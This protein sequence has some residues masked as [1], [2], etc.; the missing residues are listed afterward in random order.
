MSTSLIDN[1]NII[2]PLGG[3]E[4]LLSRVTPN[5][6]SLSLSHGACYELRGCVSDEMLLMA[7][8]YCMRK[9]P[10]LHAYILKS[11]DDDKLQY[12]AYCKGNDDELC[13]QV[14]QTIEVSSYDD[15]K[16]TWKKHLNNAVNAPSFPEDGP[17]WRLTNIVYNNPDKYIR[18]SAW[19]FCFN[20]GIDDQGSVNIIVEDIIDFCNKNGNINSIE[21]KRFPPSIEEAI[22]TGLPNLATLGWTLIQLFNSLNFPQML[23]FRLDQIKR[24]NINEY[25][26]YG[27]PEKRSTFLKFICMSPE[28]T[29]ALQQVCKDRGVKVTYVLSAAMLLVTSA[30]IQESV[31]SDALQDLRL[32]FL[33]SVGLRPYASSYY[34][35]LNNVKSNDFTNGTVACAAGAIDYIIN[36]P[37][38]STSNIQSWTGSEN[39]IDD[40]FEMAKKSNDLASLILEFVPESVRL[41]GL[42]M[43]YIDILRVVEMEAKN[44]NTMGRG[45][46]CGVSNMGIVNL[47]ANNGNLSVKGGYYGTSHTRNGVLCQLSC[48]TINNNFHGC[49]QFTN[50]LTSNNEA[51]IFTKRFERVIKS[52]SQI[53][54]RKYSNNIDNSD[55]DVVCNI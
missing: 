8:L 1:Q 2:R 33:L 6:T 24:T 30:F 19:V 28:E 41:F 13:R 54:L 37:S 14:L 52:I 42:G 9:H 22:A 10:I 34:K 36:V 5:K 26:T 50:P 38:K 48:M 45:F 3:Y 53:H 55:Y 25:E 12:F 20:H 31:G 40:I 35:T 21:T 29:N 17:Q 43:Q 27:N 47:N 23:P 51:D 11:K 49:L 39:D 18:E 7:I 44:V 4:R 46:S 15:L 32:R 16:E